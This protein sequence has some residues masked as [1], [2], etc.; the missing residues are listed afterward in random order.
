M[1]QFNQAKPAQYSK[2][3]FLTDF[4]SFPL[5]KLLDEDSFLND[6]KNRNSKIMA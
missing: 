4:L 5:N 2:L 6:F 3:L 1:D